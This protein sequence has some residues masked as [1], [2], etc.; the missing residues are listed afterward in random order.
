M[1]G[2][3]YDGELP[4]LFINNREQT[5]Y[6]N[7]IVSD[8]P[9]MVIQT[10]GGGPNQS[11][12]YSWTRDL[13]IA[14]AQ[15]VVNAF[16]NEYTIVHIRRDDQLALH[17]TAT[18]KTDF[19]GYAVLIQLSEKRLFI[20]SFG[21]H[22]AAA[23]SKPSVVCWIGNIPSQFGYEIH[24]N[25]IAHQPTIQPELRYSVLSKYNIIGTPT[26]FPYHHEAEIF[27]ADEIIAALKA[28]KKPIIKEEKQ[29][30]S[31]NR[32]KKPE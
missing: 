18:I 21:Q 31:L 11:N 9:I 8:K 17:N 4:E 19:R 20:D 10:N 30:E 24:T 15:K 16:A 22:T 6:G 32:K 3:K 13:P 25:I 12:K 2:I 1:F 27:D 23:L 29:E 28:D 5:F 26:E 7:Q 14:T